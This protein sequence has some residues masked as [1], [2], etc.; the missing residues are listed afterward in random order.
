M[1]S[2]NEDLILSCLKGAFVSFL[3]YFTIIFFVWIAISRSFKKSYFYL[4]FLYAASVSIVE[5]PY[6]MFFDFIARWLKS[7]A[8]EGPSS[9][10]MA[11]SILVM[12]FCAY[13][14]LPRYIIKKYASN[15]FSA[16]TINWALII[17]F[18]LIVVVK[19]VIYWMIISWFIK[20]AGGWDA[21][22]EKLQSLKV[23]LDSQSVQ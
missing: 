16:K 21:I 20:M 3:I 13:F 9:I 8:W 7:W 14:L 10:A 19:I 15:Y 12:L 22:S 11:I 1:L 17:S 18:I 5:I 2:A 23:H 6:W 4:S